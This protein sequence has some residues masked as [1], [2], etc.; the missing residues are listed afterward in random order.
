MLHIVRLLVVAGLLPGVA[1]AAAPTPKE[2]PAAVF[3]DLHRRATGTFYIPGAIQG[4]GD[5]DLLVDTGSSFV[6]INEAMLAA[7][8]SSGR[9]IFSHELRGC[10]ADGSDTVV[11]IYRLAGVRLGAECWIQD[12]EAAVFPGASRPIL[13]MNILVRLAPFTFSTEPPQL[14]LNQ[15]MGLPLAEFAE[16]AVADSDVAAAPEE[17]AVP[18]R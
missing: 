9:A 15:C 1:Y 17:R 13:G 6:V 11:P 3:V 18:E 10:M 12:V 16:L 14:A 7:L 2:G 4:Y 8:E 5:V